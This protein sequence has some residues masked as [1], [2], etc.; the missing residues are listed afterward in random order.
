[1]QNRPKTKDTASAVERRIFGTDGVRGTANIEPVTAE[2]ALKLGRAAAHIFTQMSMA[3]GRS[4]GRTTIVIGKDTRLS[5]YMLE[6]ALAAGVM[7]LGAD[8]L[9]IGPLPTPGVAYITRSLRA[10]AGIVL[11]ASHNPYEDNG[12]KFFR[13]DG[14]KLDDEI[15]KR[16]ENLVFSGEIEAIRPTAGKVG[17]ATRIDD[18]LGRYVEFAKQ[19]FPRGMTLEKLRVSVDVANGAAYKSTPCILRELGADVIV[20]HNDPNGRNINRECGSTYPDEIQRI[21]RETK[22]DVGI[23]HDGD[24]DRVLL[25]DEAGELVD[26]DEIMAIAALDFLRRGSLAQNTLVATVM[27]NFGLN[28]AMESH[29][30]KVVRT[31][32]GDRYVIEEMMKNDLN[33][34]GEQSGHMIFR[35]FTTTGDGI[36][37]AL[38]ILRIMIETGKPLSELKR[39]LAKYPQAQ[40]NMKVRE[41]PPLEQLLQ[42]TKLVAETERE[43]SG[44]GRVLLRYSG[45]EPKIRLL[46][47]GRDGDRINAQ[48]DLIA[49]E[50]QSSI[51][52]EA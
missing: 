51:G 7:S 31:K 22:A 15:E 38:Q 13:H 5:G 43:L 18:A 32:V 4:N 49:A 20:S 35:D 2:T 12:I 26:G 1:M 48:A 39:C 14:Y 28:E 36:V 30:G 37:S 6:N 9:L 10:D 40:R 23:S 16:I 33:V 52:V 25:C 17:R 47:E 41:K 29:G 3:A 24:A 27:S 34:G 42:V 46:I 50:I 8:V 11:S 44:A 21:M 45:T 19:S